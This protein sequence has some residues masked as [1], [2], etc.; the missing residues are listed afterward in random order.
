MSGVASRRDHDRFCQIEGWDKVRNAGGKTG[1]HHT[2]ELKLSDGNVLRT[3]IS[4]PVN[5]DTYGSR[6]WSHILSDQLDV[7]EAEFWACVDERKLPDRGAAADKAPENAMP[8]SLAYQLIHVVGVPETEVA[9]MSLERALA[10]MNEFWSKPQ[11]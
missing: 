9:T 10:L 3:R 11:D 8:A 2:Y 6:L 1:H 5:N 7:T 4:H